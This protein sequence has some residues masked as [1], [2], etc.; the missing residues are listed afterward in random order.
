MKNVIYKM[1]R[2]I[3]LFIKK[4][5]IEQNMK[6]HMMKKII[7]IKRII[8]LITKIKIRAK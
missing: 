2:T 6:Y 1:N 7:E 5:Y 8:T 4:K 3:N